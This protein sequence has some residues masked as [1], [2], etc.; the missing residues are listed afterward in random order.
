MNLIEN[1]PRSDP[2]NSTASW[3]EASLDQKNLQLVQILNLPFVVPW[4]LQLHISALLEFGGE[5]HR[6]ATDAV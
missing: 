4:N 6:V 1:C 3:P 2:G 5:M